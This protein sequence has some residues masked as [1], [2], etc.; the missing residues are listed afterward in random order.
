MDVHSPDS[1]SADTEPVGYGIVD[2]ETRIASQLQHLSAELAREQQTLFAQREAFERQAEHFAQ[3]A[4]KLAARETEIQQHRAANSAEHRSNTAD[5]NPSSDANADQELELVDLHQRYDMAISDIRELKKQNAELEKKVSAAPAKPFV[6]NAMDWEAQ[7][8]RLMA[9]LAE[10]DADN[11][12][13]AQA[14]RLQ[15]EEII[16]QT[17]AAIL[18]KQAEIDELRQQ[19]AERPVA[20]VPVSAPD[21]R[22]D[23]FDADELIRQ[24]RARLA[25]LDTQLQQQ[26]RQ[27]EIELSLH[28]AQIARATAGLTERERQFE[29]RRKTQGDS[30]S[31]AAAETKG[32]NRPR[33]WLAR[34]GLSEGD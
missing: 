1:H 27:A 16:Q 17:D 2:L 18:A 33:R 28:R 7:K 13:P 31:G 20:T 8:R 21:N 14:L 11:D 34:L 26:L 25:E 29:E 5:P 24:E 15:I 6:D 10:D 4:E 3:W 22:A 12:P 32:R 9:Q 30:H 23:L 19:L